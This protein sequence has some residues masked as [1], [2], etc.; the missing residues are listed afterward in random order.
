VGKYAKLGGAEVE[1]DARGEG[2]DD[3]DRLPITKDIGEEGPKAPPRP[4]A[5]ATTTSSVDESS[6]RDR[7]QGVGGLEVTKGA[8]RGGKPNDPTEVKASA[9]TATDC[10][11]VRPH[12]VALEW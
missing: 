7:L 6:S 4:R 10:D 2:E 11:D 3:W 5:W 12:S 9:V 8:D 1:V